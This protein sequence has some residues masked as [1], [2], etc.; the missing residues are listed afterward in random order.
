M[1]ECALQV[2]ELQKGVQAARGEQ[3]AVGR[4]LHF[5]HRVCM[6]GQGFARSQ[7]VQIPQP[8]GEKEKMSDR[9][10]TWLYRHQILTRRFG[11]WLG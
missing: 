7:V 8:E 2:P 11:G 5:H 10:R 6:T 9:G 3:L 1:E 4:K